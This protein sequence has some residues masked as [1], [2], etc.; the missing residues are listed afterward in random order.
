MKRIALIFVLILTGCAASS[1][2]AANKTV[3]AMDTVMELT[4]YGDGRNEALEAAEA[5]IFRLDALLDRGDEDSDV[6][7]LNNGL[8]VSAETEEL[9]MRAL[10]IGASTGWAFDVS[11]APLIDA[12]G[13]YDGKYRVPTEDELSKAMERV[14]G[15]KIG[16]DLEL[17][18]AEIDLGGIAKGYASE[19]AAEI[20]KNRGIT[21]ALL[22]LG[23][24][25]RA[26]GS[27][28][29]GSPWR[30]AVQN[31]D[32]GDY[33]G[34]L[35]LADSAA[36]TSGDY[37]RYFESGGK[38][39]HHIIDPKTGRPA[40]SGLR[41]VTV[42]CGDAALADGLSTALFVMGLEG[43]GDCW[44]GGTYDF[45]AVFVTDDGGVFITSGLE[46]RFESESEYE[47]IK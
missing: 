12:W 1:P 2:E 39:Y 6:S 18:G 15:E 4:V 35:T 38:R 29:D 43:A 16:P 10:D 13:F 11:V 31:P 9:V 45:E 7:R 36:V 40:E 19:R 37:Q 30:V 27:R 44:R 42:V 21:S 5:E 34:V 20:L 41:S 25:V 8:P 3:F 28:P 17:N 23:G 22:S 26:V 47:V 24:N 32:G 33:I 14:G 46:G